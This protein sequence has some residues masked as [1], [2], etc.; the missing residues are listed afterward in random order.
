MVF[1]TDK[2]YENY[3]DCFNDN[4]LPIAANSSADP[5]FAR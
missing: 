2:Y 1:Q 3:A 5:N 4:I